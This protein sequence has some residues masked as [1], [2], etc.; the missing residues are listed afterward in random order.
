ML[1]TVWVWKSFSGDGDMEKKQ[2]RKYK[3][4]FDSGNK[5]RKNPVVWLLLQSST[6]ESFYNSFTEYI[7]LTETQKALFFNVL[8][9]VSISTWQACAPHI[10]KHILMAIKSRK[11]FYTILTLPPKALAHGQLQR[12]WCSVA[13][14]CIG[15]FQVFP[16]LCQ[17]TQSVFGSSVSEWG[18]NQI[19]KTVLW[20]LT[21]VLQ[22]LG[23]VYWV[24]LRTCSTEFQDAEFQESSLARIKQT[25]QRSSMWGKDFLWLGD[26]L[27][28]HH[29]SLSFLYFSASFSYAVPTWARDIVEATQASCLSLHSP[30]SSL[31]EKFSVRCGKQK[32]CCHC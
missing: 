10:Q 27:N 25:L 13:W 24:S 9:C 15:C 7:L 17:L 31:W 28:S 11:T 18:I 8:M 6:E 4:E 30:E 2:Q 14:A 32:P 23:C 20:T 22:M 3:W 12:E 5:V 16:L 19:S 26:N 1:C 21:D 29:A